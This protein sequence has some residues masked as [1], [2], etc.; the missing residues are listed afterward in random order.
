V[1]LAD[2]LKKRER[3][4]YSQNGEDGEPHAEPG[5][6]LKF[7]R[8]LAMLVRGTRMHSTDTGL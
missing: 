8:R 5:A 2:D 6:R 4:V 1:T 7:L 3:N